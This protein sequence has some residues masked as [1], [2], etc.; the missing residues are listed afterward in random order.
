MANI[1][2]I[3]KDEQDLALGALIAKSEGYK[4]HHITNLEEIR[5]ALSGIPDWFVIYDGEDPTLTRSLL[6]IVPKYV[7]PSKIFAFTKLGLE[8]YKHLMNFPLFSHHV[9]RSFEPPA[10]EF[11]R[12]LFANSLY[13]KPRG[14]EPFFKTGEAPDAV[15]I[16]SF[17]LL[18][19][20]H[21]N[22]AVAAIQNTLT[23]LGFP[24]RVSQAVA[25]ATDELIL[26]ALFDA[27]VDE[28][29]KRYRH[30]AARDA[31]FTLTDKEQIHVEFAMGPTYAGICVAD[32]YGSIER[33]RVFTSVRNC[34]QAR[35]ASEVKQGAGFGL[36][37]IM[38][39][40]LGLMLLAQPSHRTEA[41]LFFPIVK[42]F[43]EFRNSFKFFSILAAD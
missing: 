13:M 41:M 17:Q 42:D 15:K 4:F 7:K 11:Y 16:R 12:K 19:T 2:V 23:G 38:R 36:Q 31:D 30:A 29:R 20:T 26:N 39:S 1:M 24:S 37:G 43:K 21:K 35:P 5:A 28:Y 10:P 3:S 22:A 40:G 8:K 14:L 18:R 34:L 25:Q 6:E 33:S 32:Q 27:P 9:R